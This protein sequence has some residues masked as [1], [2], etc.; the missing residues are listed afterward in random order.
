ME[1]RLIRYEH[2][3]LFAI[4]GDMSFDR[5]L[6]FY[7]LTCRNFNGDSASGVVAA[8]WVGLVFFC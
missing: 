3:E 6:G 1:L 7:P 2:Y 4:V 5:F 8:T